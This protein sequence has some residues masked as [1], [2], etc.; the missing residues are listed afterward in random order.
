MLC[1]NVLQVAEDEVGKEESKVSQHTIES[2]SSKITAAASE[3]K[4]AKGYVVYSQQKP[5]RKVIVS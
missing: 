4:L 2:T 5:K 3:I 1:L